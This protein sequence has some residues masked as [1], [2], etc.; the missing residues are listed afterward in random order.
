[1]RIAVSI[2]PVHRIWAGAGGSGSARA[3][4]C[5]FVPGVSAKRAK[6]GDRE[7]VFL[8][9]TG[10]E[11]GPFACHFLHLTERPFYVGELFMRALGYLFTLVFALLVGGAASAQKGKGWLGADVQDVTKAEADTRGD[12]SRGA[13]VGVVAS[14]SPA[15]KAYVK[16]RRHHP[17][18]R[19][20]DD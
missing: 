3:L 14:G 20:N 2:G 9:I 13:K 7:W 6:R 15:E 16:N 11:D 19:P 8:P 17:I 18:D 5:L 4:A 12:S 1:M 10:D